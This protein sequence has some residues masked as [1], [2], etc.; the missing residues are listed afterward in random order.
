MRTMQATGC[1]CRR[2]GSDDMPAWVCLEC[3]L[4]AAKMLAGASGVDVLS[5]LQEF[6][7]AQVTVCKNELSRAMMFADRLATEKNE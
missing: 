2:S 3:L 7:E 5:K 6:A 4:K 1:C